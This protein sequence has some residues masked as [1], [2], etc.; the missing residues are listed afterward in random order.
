MKNNIKMPFSL[1]IIC[2]ML[3]I[4]VLTYFLFFA[5]VFGR[6]GK[7][8]TFSYNFIPFKEILRYLTK[9]SY[10]GYKIVILNIVGNIVCFMPFGFF[11]ASVL[12][13]PAVHV[14]WKTTFV[15]AFL[16]GFMETIQYITKT[17]C[18]DIDDVILN[19]FGGYLGYVVFAIIFLRRINMGQITDIRNEKI[20]ELKTYK[21]AAGQEKLKLK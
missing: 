8:V 15:S 1:R 5:E 20:V 16:S 14:A 21:D 18:C 4:V 19:T 9:A 2:L 6:D 3:W 17:G 13:Y 7:I 10:F 12:K 11:F